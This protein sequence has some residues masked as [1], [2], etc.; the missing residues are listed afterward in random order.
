MQS[1]AEAAQA[2]ESKLDEFA[3][4]IRKHQKT[5][6][7][8]AAVCLLWRELLPLAEGPPAHLKE[9]W[10]ELMKEWSWEMQ[11]IGFLLQNLLAP[12]PAASAERAVR[13]LHL[14]AWQ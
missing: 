11:Q 14:Q 3:I 5:S 4:N 2:V 9:L 6:S 8:P 1:L 13:W 12:P 7:P 10:R